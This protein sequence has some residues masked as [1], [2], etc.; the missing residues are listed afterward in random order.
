M[1]GGIPVAVAGSTA[2]RTD[3]LAPAGHDRTWAGGS[4]NLVEIYPD[5]I[6]VSVI[7]IDGAPQ[8]FDLD[9]DGCADVIAEFPTQQ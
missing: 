5:T 8:V 4:F 3:P 1:L 2:I 7:P 6:A 9:A